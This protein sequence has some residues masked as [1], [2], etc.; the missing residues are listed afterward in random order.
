MKCRSCYSCSRPYLVSCRLSLLVEIST[1]AT[2]DQRPWRCLKGIWKWPTLSS[3][4][5]AG[6]G[7]K[8]SRRSE[9]RVWIDALK[10][11]T[12]QFLAQ[13]DLSLIPQILIIAQTKYCMIPA[14]IYVAFMSWTVNKTPIS[15]FRCHL[16]CGI[17]VTFEKK[18]VKRK[19]ACFSVV[20]VFCWSSV[21]SRF[22]PEARLSPQQPFHKRVF[23]CVT[24]WKGESCVSVSKTQAC[25]HVLFAAHDKFHLCRVCTWKTYYLHFYHHQSLWGHRWITRSCY[26]ND[27]FLFWK[28][29]SC[30]QLLKSTRLP[31]ICPTLVCFLN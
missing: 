17:H 10:N 1:P 3:V 24:V 7:G 5:L 8:R 26:G 25:M 15:R 23:V 30:E 19:E 9:L 2:L 6:A 22:P 14:D 11:Q 31:N 4:Y 21:V 18:M 27:S 12:V 16:K 29:I 20:K 13:I 28:V